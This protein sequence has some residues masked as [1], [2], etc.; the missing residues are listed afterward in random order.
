MSWGLGRVP[1]G[2]RA[3]LSVA[4]AVMVMRSGADGA[5]GSDSRLELVEIE[6]EVAEMAYAAA[7]SLGGRRVA[8]AMSRS[9]S[10]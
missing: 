2:G 3:L 7:R 9:K 5:G 10:P 6:A 8:C 4:E 1:I